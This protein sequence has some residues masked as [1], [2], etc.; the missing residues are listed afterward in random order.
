MLVLAPKHK[1]NTT[2]TPHS[3]LFVFWLHFVE[4][5]CSNL[6]Q[7]WFVSFYSFI[8][9]YIFSVMRTF[10]VF[11]IV[12]LFKRRS[13]ISAKLKSNPGVSGNSFW[14]IFSWNLSS[15]ILFSRNVTVLDSD[16]RTGF[17]QLSDNVG[18]ERQ[19]RRRKRHRLTHTIKGYRSTN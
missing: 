3:L 9:F 1:Q 7:V 14:R 18:I 6:L 12:V 2:R 10:I 11:W 16:V 13:F 5:L 15:G 17:V 19:E 8:S 4:V